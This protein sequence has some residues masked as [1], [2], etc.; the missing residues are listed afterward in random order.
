VWF[1]NSFHPRDET[2]G[3]LRALGSLIEWS[4]R[5]LLAVDAADLEH[6]QL[7]ADFLTECEKAGQLVD[8]AGRSWAP[9]SAAVQGSMTSEEATR[10]ALSAPWREL[11]QE[12]EST[13]VP[14]G[15]ARHWNISDE[16]MDLW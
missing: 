1:G 16:A 10:F 15:D 11:A 12:R 9:P 6:A 2:A 8:E 5:N 7:V 4:S 3:K 13:V 14:A